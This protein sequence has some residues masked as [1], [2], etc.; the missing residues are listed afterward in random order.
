VLW[1]DAALGIEWPVADPILSEKDR[2]GTPLRDIARERLPPWTGH[3]A[4]H[5][6]EP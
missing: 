3:P 1:D 6:T 5:A 4:L 2:Q